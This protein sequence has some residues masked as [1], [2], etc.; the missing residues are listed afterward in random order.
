MIDHRVLVAPAADVVR[1]AAEV[2]LLAPATTVVGGGATRQQSVRAGLAAARAHI[3]TGDAIALVHDAARPF[4]SDALI[5]R[6]I[7]AAHRHGAAIPVLPLADTV[8]R[9]DDTGHVNATLERAAL[10]AVQTPQAFRL[11][12]IEAAH[13]SA[14][15]DGSLDDAALVEAMGR[16]VAT[17]AGA[18]AAFKLT[19]PD[20]LA[21]AR[22]L[23][24][25]DRPQADWQPRT[26]IGFDV[27]QTTDGDHVMLC[28]VRIPHER[29]LL[30]HSDADVGLH[31]LADALYAALG[32]GDIGRHFPP[33][34]ARWKSAQST[35]FLA[36]AAGRVAA[37]G[38]RITHLSVV[39][40]AEAPRINPYREAMRAAVAQAAGIGRDAVGVTATTTEGL[41]F[42][43]RRE[44]LAAMATA[45]ILIA[46]QP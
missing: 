35:Q 24:Q 37:R 17:F 10:R 36:H 22:R 2:E 14:S 7:D 1:L 13:A 8:K 38:G 4:V 21:R 40:L 19:T 25:N 39:L 23:L 9:I 34:D 11:S 12:V 44:G 28:G 33:S 41:G 20:D 45:T 18:E 6:A 31:A 15:A 5:T 30:G 29:G 42:T 16:P 3:G 46:E 43:G 26:G 27:H 32:E